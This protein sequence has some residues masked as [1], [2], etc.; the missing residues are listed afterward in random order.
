VLKKLNINA[1]VICESRGAQTR[2]AVVM[3]NIYNQQ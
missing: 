2:D 1:N 3:K